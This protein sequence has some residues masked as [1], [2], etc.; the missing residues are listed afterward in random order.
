MDRRFICFHDNR[1]PAHPPSTQNQALGA[2]LLLYK[3]VLAQPLP[4]L[5]DLVHAH[6][7]RRLPVVLTRAEV[8]AILHRLEGTPRRMAT[9][10]YGAGLRLLERARLRIKDADLTKHQ[11]LV[12]HLPPF[13]RDAPP[14]RRL[15]HPH[16]PGTSG[17]PGCQHHDDLYPCRE[18][19][20]GCGAHSRRPPADGCRAC[21]GRRTH[22]R[23]P[24]CIHG[25]PARDTMTRT[26]SQR[27]VLL[28][29]VAGG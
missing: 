24:A 20:V 5:D 28:S 15:R 26:V 6:R 16:R 2:L 18:P 27:R 17:P 11:V 22:P 3:E 29:F 23:R 7:P 9:L 19:G 14:G 13:L 21:L 10:L 8:Y 4:W 25:R 1:Q 12:P